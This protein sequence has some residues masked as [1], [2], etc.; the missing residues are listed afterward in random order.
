MSRRDD[1]R[2]RTACPAAPAL[3]LPSRAGVGLRHPHVLGFLEERPATAFLEVHS[4]NYLGEGG[5]R[6]RALFDLARDY[7]LSFH[8]VGL[9]M[10]SAEGLDRV[11][12]RRLGA[13]FADYRP[14]L[15]SEHLSWSV[16]GGSY[17]NDLLPLP[18]TEEALALVCR[19]LDQAQEAFGR[20]ILLENPSS[21]LRFRH[22]TIAEPEFLAEVQRRTGCGLLLDVN[23]VYVSAQ[24]HGLDALA[25]LAAL[26]AEAVG[27]IHLAGHSRRPVG[28]QVLLI[29]DHGSAVIP[30][31]WQL[32][33]AALALTGPRPT[34]I[35]WDSNIP[36]LPVLLAEAAKADRRLVGLDVAEGQHVA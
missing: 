1:A 32:Y 36:E 19:N 33:E 28:D 4:E 9:S 2:A 11:H 21:Y 7:P 31:V 34:L 29:D 27:E 14:A 10:G 3:P 20:R 30:A 22:S 5:P 35:E 17:L 18:Y 6:R 8:G 13:L 12:L 16:A 24:N 26:P 15:V 25:Y 23:N